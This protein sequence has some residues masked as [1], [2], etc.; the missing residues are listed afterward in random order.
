MRKLIF[1]FLKNLKENVRKN[2]IELKFINYYFFVILNSSFFSI[3]TKNKI[4]KFQI[5]TFKKIV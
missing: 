3:N 4:I 1:K 5:L 2:K